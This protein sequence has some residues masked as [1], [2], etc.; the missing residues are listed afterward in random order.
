[1]DLCLLLRR[2]ELLYVSDQAVEGESNS[3]VFHGVLSIEERVTRLVYC[4]VHL[5]AG[6]LTCWPAIDRQF[7]LLRSELDHVAVVVSDIIG[8]AFARMG[9]F[10]LF[11]L[12]VHALSLPAALFPIRP[13][14]LLLSSRPGAGGQ[15]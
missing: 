8:Y 7:R 1:M 6:A 9:Q 13:H 12:N 5:C 3:L 15:R 10:V 11:P 2:F 14:E 4:P